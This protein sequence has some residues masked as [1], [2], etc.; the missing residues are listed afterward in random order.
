MNQLPTVLISA[1]M[2]LCLATLAHAENDPRESYDGYGLNT[3]CGDAALLAICAEYDK[4]EKGSSICHV[5]SNPELFGSK[6]HHS[7]GFLMALSAFYLPAGGMPKDQIDLDYS[8]TIAPEDDGSYARFLVSVRVSR[9][10]LP[11]KLWG[12]E[13]TGVERLAL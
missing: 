2:A 1:M 12:C 6:I 4:T 3:A 7:S 9:T 8:T 13:V 5:V 10:A 11:Y